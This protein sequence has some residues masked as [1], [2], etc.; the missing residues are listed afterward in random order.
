MIIGGSHYC[1]NTVSSIKA[2]Q[3]KAESSA[4]LSPSLDTQNNVITFE[5]NKTVGINKPHY[6]PLV[7]E[8]VIR[9]L[10]VARVL[11][12]TGSTVDVM[13]CGTLQK[14]NVNLDEVTPT[15]IPLTGFSGTTSMTLRLIKLPVMAKGVRRIVDFAVVNHQ[16]IY[17]LIMGTPWINSMKA[18]PST[19]HLCIKFPTPNETAIIWGIQ[20]QSR[21]ISQISFIENT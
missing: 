17:K 11:V 1:H 13:F 4:N 8:I 5:E 19:Y 7:I 12:D 6:N 14:M 2:Y 20:K 3:Q 21:Q 10:E 16:A 15:P 9:D 18:V